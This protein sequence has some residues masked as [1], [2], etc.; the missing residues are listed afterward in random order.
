MEL[1]LLDDHVECYFEVPE[2]FKKYYSPNVM[3]K[4][5]RTLYSMIQAAYAFWTTLLNVMWH[6]KYN[7]CNTDPCL[8]YCWSKTGLVLW[9]PWVDDCLVC[10]LQENVEEVKNDLKEPFDCDDLGN[11]MEYIACKIDHDKNSMKFTQPVLM[12]SFEDLIMQRMS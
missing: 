7:R 5:F 8:Y 2:G 4:L 11:M 12:Q 3:L 6:M 10:G 9:L 1:F